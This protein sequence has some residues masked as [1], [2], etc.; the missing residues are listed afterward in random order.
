MVI[1]T[2]SPLHHASGKDRFF[3]RTDLRL[4]IPLDVNPER[5]HPG[6]EGQPAA[7]RLGRGNGINRHARPVFGDQRGSTAG[8]GEGKDRRRR[9]PLSAT[10]QAAWPIASGRLR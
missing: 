1:T 5:A 2:T 7:H 3:N 10:R 4:G 6:I 9:R 8:L